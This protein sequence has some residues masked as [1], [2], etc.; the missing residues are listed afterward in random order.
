MMEINQHDLVTGKT[1]TFLCDTR[2]AEKRAESMWDKE[3]GTIDWLRTLTPESKL[4]DVGANVGVYT[5]FASVVMGAQ[6]IAFEPESQ[7]FAALCRNILANSVG[8]LV[9]PYP[10]AVSKKTDVGILKA[11]SMQAGKSGHQIMDEG[12][13][14]TGFK[15]SELWQG[16][17]V[18]ALDDMKILPT[19]IKIDTDGR[20][21][22]IIAG[23]GDIMFNNPDLVSVLVEYDGSWAIAP[24]M[25]RRNLQL[26]R[27]DKCRTEGMENRIYER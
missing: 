9:T 18:T 19:H 10:F 1:I 21:R 26:A 16:V 22:D 27:I 3:P 12:P 7:N 4:L 2:M 5:L 24:Y 25:G 14:E 20:E 6:V 15:A 11:M 23:A 17:F 8:D 13:C